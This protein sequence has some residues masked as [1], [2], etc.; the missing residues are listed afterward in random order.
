MASN[1]VTALWPGMCERLTPVFTQLYSPI[2]VG[3]SID[4]S[5]PVV[6][7][8]SALSEKPC[9]GPLIF[10]D[11]ETSDFM[12]A[13]IIE[14][15]ALS[16]SFDSL[17]DENVK[18]DYFWQLINPGEGTVLSHRAVKIHG[19]T[20]NMLRMYGHPP[21][22]TFQRFLDWSKSKSP[23]FFVAHNATFDRQMLKNSFTKY[24]INHKLSKF[25]CTMKMAS[26][27]SI[28]NR[29][30]GTV[31]RHFNYINQ[32]AHRSLTDAEVCAYIFA[33]MSLMGIAP[34]NRI[35]KKLRSR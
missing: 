25:L 6:C 32:Q 16:V 20:R 11:T 22:E 1:D 8:Q 31:A 7:F 29:K 10:V 30:L 24:G 2:E 18:L 35:T 5:T 15:G 17:E 14:L 21:Q 13:D 34:K 3:E 26:N 33:K 23:D 28:E 19:I 4:Q 27:L 12:D 9:Y